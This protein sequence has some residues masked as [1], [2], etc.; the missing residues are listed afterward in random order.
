VRGAPVALC[1]GR[2]PRLIDSRE[3]CQQIDDGGILYDCPGRSVA[4]AFDNLSRDKYNARTHAHARNC[5]K[6]GGH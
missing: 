6:L 2:G 5:E 4:E 3:L 1:T